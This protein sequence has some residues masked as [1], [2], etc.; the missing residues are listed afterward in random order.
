MSH[1]EFAR[2]LGISRAN[3]SDIEK[4]RKLLSPAMAFM[5]AQTLGESEAL[6]IQVALQ[7][8]IAA[9]GL[10]FSSCVNPIVKGI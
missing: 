7:G 10:R 6:W 9:A 5:F 2:M 8:E 3:L 4:S 1:A